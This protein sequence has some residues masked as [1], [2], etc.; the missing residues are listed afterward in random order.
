MTLRIQSILFCEGCQSRARRKSCNLH[1]NFHCKFHCSSSAYS[2][3]L[4]L[5]AT[6]QT[7]GPVLSSSS[8]DSASVTAATISA[9][10]THRCKTLLPP[11]VATKPARNGAP[12]IT[13]PCS[14][15]PHSYLRDADYT[16]PQPCVIY[17]Q[18]E[19]CCS[20]GPRRRFLLQSQPPPPEATK[21]PTRSIQW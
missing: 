20:I 13:H 11:E 9:N 4:D 1:S 8:S 19:I 6:L 21:A 12:S 14:S 3:C 2:S 15:R 10:P 5:P 17:T 7:F 18:A 16:R